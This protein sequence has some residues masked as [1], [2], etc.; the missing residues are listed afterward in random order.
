MKPFLFI[1]DFDGTITAQDFFKQIYLRYDPEKIFNPSGKRGFKLLKETLEGT[2]LK[3][4]DFEKEI[5]HIP[6][7]PSFVNFYEFLKKK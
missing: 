4:E 6:M 7:D 3:E 5:V 2:N 1:S